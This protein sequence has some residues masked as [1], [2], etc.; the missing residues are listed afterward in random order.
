MFR[1]QVSEERGRSKKLKMLR[2]RV[3]SETFEYLYFTLPSVRSATIIM[4]VLLVATL[5]RQAK[6][7]FVIFI[8]MYARSIVQSV[9]WTYLQEEKF[10]ANFVQHLQK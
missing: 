5:L 1:G 8:A 7:A 2:V 3:V 4:L 6:K 10:S 9:E